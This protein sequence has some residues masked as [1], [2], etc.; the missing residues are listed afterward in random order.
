MNKSMNC[1]ILSLQRSPHDLSGFMVT[2]TIMVKNIRH[3]QMYW[4]P[5]TY[6]CIQHFL[7]MLHEYYTTQSKMY[8]IWNRTICAVR[9]TF[10]CFNA[11]ILHVYM[12]QDYST[13]IELTFNDFCYGESDVFFIILTANITAASL[14]DS[15]I[16]I[17]E[18]DIFFKLK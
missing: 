12:P 4:I 16:I 17:Q 5:A 3:Q 11:E 15:N 13:E 8:V 14:G 10:G 2:T 1:V 7:A 9:I 18:E 6:R